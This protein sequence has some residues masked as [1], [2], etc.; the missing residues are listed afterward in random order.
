MIVE[1][2]LARNRPGIMS[3]LSQTPTEGAIVA[4]LPT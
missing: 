3:P 4:P 2:V 1:D